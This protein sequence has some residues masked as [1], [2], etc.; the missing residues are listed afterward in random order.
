MHKYRQTV[1]EAPLRFEKGYSI[2]KSFTVDLADN[3]WLTIRGIK[4]PADYQ[5]TLTEPTPPDQF[6]AYFRVTSEG[7]TMAEGDNSSN[8]RRPASL[9]KDEFARFIGDF[10]AEPNRT[11]ELSLR[12]ND[13]AP[14]ILSR[15]AKVA[16]YL[17]FHVREGANY[18]AA[19]L[20]FAG[21]GSGLVGLLLASPLWYF[22]IQRLLRRRQS[23]RVERDPIY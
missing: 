13:A 2:T 5:F 7:K 18:L 8:P 20:R 14:G 9:S 21:I 4:Y 22:L 3:Y 1:L 6:S 17:D 15:D 12:I 19:L 11:Y 23:G 16:V 10:H